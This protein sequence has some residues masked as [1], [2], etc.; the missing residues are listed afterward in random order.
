MKQDAIAWAS[1]GLLSLVWGATFAVTGVALGGFSPLGV[2]C[3]RIL[4]AA[5]ATYGVLRAL[6]LS[7]PRGRA[8]WGWCAALGLT[9]LLAPFTLLSWGQQSIPSSLAALF[10]SGSPLFVL[11][12][13]RV[14]L[15]EAVGA[16]RWLGFAVGLSGLVLLIGPGI[17]GEVGAGQPILPQ[18][19]CL[20]AAFCYALSGLVIR[21]MPP[22]HPVAG[23]AAS[24]LAAAAMALPLLPFAL[25]AAMPATGPLI[26][27]AVLGLVQTGLAHL[28]RYQ[29]VRRS[30]QVFMSMV[31]Y[32][33]PVWATVLGVAVL[34]ERLA[35]RDYG[36]F[37]LIMAGLAIAQ[38][39][40][41]TWRPAA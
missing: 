32:L 26:A 10:I 18:L 12:L 13:T 14:V 35:P 25:P 39:R 29:V 23:T 37:A 11:L 28:L 19:A 5:F 41:R 9:G 36:A 16:H 34:G 31:S 6:G 24:Q 2:A 33:I 30:G 4:L 15:R 8:T 27:V 38:W 20:G 22:V 17:L 21:R 3:G 7:L 1:L 40:P